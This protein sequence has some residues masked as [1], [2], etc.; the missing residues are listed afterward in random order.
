[1]GMVVVDVVVT[2][3]RSPVAPSVAVYD[4]EYPTETSRGVVPPRWAEERVNSIVQSDVPSPVPL[5][6]ECYGFCGHR[7]KIGFSGCFLVLTP[8]LVDVVG[9]SVP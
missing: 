7:R 6:L 8:L 3:P 9:G 2:A 5:G 1:M 4:T